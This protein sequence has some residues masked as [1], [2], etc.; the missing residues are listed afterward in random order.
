MKYLIIIPA[1]ALIWLG[2]NDAR[3]YRQGVAL[4]AVAEESIAINDTMSNNFGN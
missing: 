2:V 1:V 3:D 4:R